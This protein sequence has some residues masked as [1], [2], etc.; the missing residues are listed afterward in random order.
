MV[1]SISPK[2]FE[3]TTQAELTHAAG[4]LKALD[5]VQSTLDNLRDAI[6]GET[7]KITKMYPPRLEEAT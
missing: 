1:Y 4:H 3:V 6:N 7:C 5:E 2:L